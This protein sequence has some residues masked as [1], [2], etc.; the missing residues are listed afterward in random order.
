MKNFKIKIILN[1]LPTKENLHKRHPST[2]TSPTYNRYQ[3]QVENFLHVL[4]CN[5]NTTDIRTIIEKSVGHTT[6][7]YGIQLTDTA[8]F[9]EKF[10]EEHIT[11]QKPTP[12]AIIYK[13]CKLSKSNR[14]NNTKKDDPTIY[15]YHHIIKST[16]DEIWQPRCTQSH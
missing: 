14:T 7:K 6:N 1:K 12:I 13:S 9:V 4:I 8:I 16:R 15:L 11:N 3:N 10:I 2:Y 5:I